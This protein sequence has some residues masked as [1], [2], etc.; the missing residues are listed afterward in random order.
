[1]QIHAC[2]LALHTGRP[3]KMAYGRSESFLGHVHRHPARIWM[4]TGATRDGDL[5]NVR[6][7]LLIDGGAYAS[8]S[9]AVI[10][11]ASTFAAGPY[12]VPN[13]LI[14][15]TCVFTN[16]P[17]CGAMRGFGAVQVCFAHEGQMDKLAAA[18]PMDPVQLRLRNAAATGTVLPTGQAIRGAAPVAEVLD[19]A[20]RSRMPPARARPARTPS[21]SRAASP[22]TSGA[23]RAFAA[24]SGS[25]SATRT[26]RTAGGSTI[27]RRR[28]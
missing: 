1:M 12:D 16:N 21:S 9:I 7:R 4:R 24:A 27:R 17:P 15:G 26:S 13:A 18:L 25:R 14:D 8:S 11:N 5:V 22:A 2:M 6:A 28:G 19:G 23:A 3:V 20:R 10:S